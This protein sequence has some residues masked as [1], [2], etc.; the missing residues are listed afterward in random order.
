[1]KKR[2]F[3]RALMALVQGY[4]VLISPVI[5]GGC[6]FA[7]SCSQYAH[8]ALEA[9]G[10]VKGSVLTM[11]RL[12]RCHPW[13]GHGFDPVPSAQVRPETTAETTPARLC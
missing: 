12:C 5:P 8:E 2:I 4:R 1:M 7:P 13:G 3:T 11:K 6:R 10:A 9:H